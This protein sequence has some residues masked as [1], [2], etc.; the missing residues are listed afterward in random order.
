MRYAF[1]TTAAFVFLG[2]YVLGRAQIVDRHAIDLGPMT[3]HLGMSRDAAVA[4]LSTYYSVNDLG[5]VTTKSGPPYESVG[6]VVFKSDKLSE[7]RKDW[8]PNNQEHG[9]ELA[10]NLFGILDGLKTRRQ[11]N[12]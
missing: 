2:G 3:L 8:S 10:S 7:V 9:Y 5:M 1:L 11:D 4:A 6:Q 12:M